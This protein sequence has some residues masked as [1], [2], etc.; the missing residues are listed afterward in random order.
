M[1]SHGLTKS[2]CFGAA[3]AIAFFF[4]LH[5][6]APLVGSTD[7]FVFYLSGCT[8]AYAAMLGSTPRRAARNAAAAFMGTVVVGMFTSGMLAF[9]I[10]LTSVIALVRSGLEYP[11][12]S[13][14]GVVIELLLGGLG[15]GFA[16]WVASPSWVGAAAGFWAFSLVQSLYFLVPGFGVRESQADSGDPFERARE[17]LLG[18]L[19]EV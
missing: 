18:L 19:E 7:V 9:V 12:R 14:R 16:A 5:L 13:V 10:G 2:L 6:G 1:R 8:I 17:Q 3:A 15:L 4:V 11:A